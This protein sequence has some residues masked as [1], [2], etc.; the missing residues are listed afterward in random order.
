MGQ[1]LVTVVLAA[2]NGA[3][4][5][6]EQVE[7]ILAQ[8]GVEL[9]LVIIDDASTDGTSG[10]IE[11][12]AESHGDRVRAIRHARNLGYVAT[13]EEGI[14]E[15][16]GDFIALSD[17]DDVWVRGK[18]ERLVRALEG[19][20]ALAFSDLELV[21]ETLRPLGDGMWKRLGFSKRE[22]ALM[23]RGESFRVLL[24]R[25][26]VNGC[27]LLARADFAKAVLPFPPLED[28]VH[29]QWLALAASL[30]GGLAAV[31]ERLVSYRQH[32]GQQ[33]GAGI[34]ASRKPVDSGPRDIEAWA[35]GWEG[36]FEAA[37]RMGAEPGALAQARA[38]VKAREEALAWRNGLEAVTQVL[39]GLA[40]GTYHRHFSG[41][42]SA[43]RD[44]AR[45]L[46]IR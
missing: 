27:A 43:A 5:L 9:E 22:R 4:H 42:R 24:R 16:K 19:G 33:T 2:Y 37:S 39:E 25:N 21:D 8:R 32:G 41:W 11:A 18:L 26:V 17:Q 15:A 34:G 44:F 35:R 14:R 10:L 40:S 1:G 20:A 12:L 30:T 38:S 7:S 36:L 3:A 6:G 45:C 46:G 13:F 31:P 29:D 23:T 28:F